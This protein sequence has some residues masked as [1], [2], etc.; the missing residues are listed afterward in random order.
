[1]Y[2]AEAQIFKNPYNIKDDIETDRLINH[3]ERGYVENSLIM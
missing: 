3:D 1:M 2:D